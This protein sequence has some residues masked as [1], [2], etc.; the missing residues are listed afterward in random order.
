MEAQGHR[1]F[2]GICDKLTSAGEQLKSG[3]ASHLVAREDNCG[4]AV[5][6]TE[7]AIIGCPV[8][9]HTGPLRLIK[10]GSF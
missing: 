9:R 8:V 2:S 10:K 7:L 1:A 6:G 5:R 4:M 3:S